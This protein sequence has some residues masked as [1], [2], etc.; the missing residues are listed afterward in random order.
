VGDGTLRQLIFGDYRI[1]TVNAIFISRMC[2][3]NVLG[4]PSLL[5]SL[6]A[7]TSYGN[8]KQD[9]IHVYGP[10]GI[11][12]F[13]ASAMNAVEIS[14]TKQVIVHELCLTANDVAGLSHVHF[15]WIRSKHKY[16][17][18][19][20]DSIPIPNIRLERSYPT[21]SGLWQLMSDDNVR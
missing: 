13:I 1:S 15:P 21:E 14:L 9:D 11:Y 3:I 6:A 17:D 5:F 19:F 2:S 8:D 10:P 4:L 20:S 16:I 18:Y 7:S 12:H